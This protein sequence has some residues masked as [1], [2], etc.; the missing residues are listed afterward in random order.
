MTRENAIAIIAMVTEQLLERC[1]L[2]ALLTE[3]Q[4]EDMILHNA[5]HLLPLKLNKNELAKLK[6]CNKFWGEQ[7]E[8]ESDIFHQIMLNSY[9]NS[10]LQL[11]S[12]LFLHTD[13]EE[14]YQG[15]EG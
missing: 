8:K 7:G 2:P 14:R 10:P 6:R 1:K 4:L 13:L 11:H 3:T 5:H 15:S 9:S 12:A